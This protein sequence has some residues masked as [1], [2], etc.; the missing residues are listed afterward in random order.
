MAP[1]TCRRSRNGLCGGLV[2]QCV[3]QPVDKGCD[4]T[5]GER[6][7]EGH[8]SHQFRPIRRISTPALASELILTAASGKDCDMIQGARNVL[9]DSEN[10]LVAALGL[11]AAFR[12]EEGARLLALFVVVAQQCL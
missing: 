8:D 11:M 1:K 2:L 6:S 3:W 5:G 12:F 7:P 4:E 10:Y 9:E